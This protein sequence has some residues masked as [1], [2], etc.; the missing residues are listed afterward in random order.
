MHRNYGEEISGRKENLQKV[1]QRRAKFKIR[2]TMAAV[3]I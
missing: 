3:T 2:L 1:R